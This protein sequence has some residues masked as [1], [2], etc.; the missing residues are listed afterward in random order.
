MVQN[1]QMPQPHVQLK[2][3]HGHTDT[4]V[5]IQ[6]SQPINN[7]MLTPEQADEFA[8][9]VLHSK[10]LLAEHQEKKREAANG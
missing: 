6:F 3:N 10:Q 8:K 2:T 4:H 1:G 9:Q 5:V 7:I